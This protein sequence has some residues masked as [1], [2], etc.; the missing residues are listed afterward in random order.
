M[1]EKS[2]TQRY[3]E[4][5]A[6]CNKQIAI[7]EPFLK[8]FSQE[9]DC[10]TCFYTD[11]TALSGTSA[12]GYKYFKEKHPDLF[13]RWQKGEVSVYNIK[14]AGATFV[15]DYKQTKFYNGQLFINPIKIPI[16][17]FMIHEN[18]EYPVSTYLA[19]AVKE[20]HAAQEYRGAIYGAHRAEIESYLNQKNMA[21]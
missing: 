5:D 10:G 3:A 14:W 9:H 12:S 13:N 1:T 18:K 19:E 20:L 8:R 17:S 2:C 21:R 4:T 6:N 7:I 11:I 16:H 15:T